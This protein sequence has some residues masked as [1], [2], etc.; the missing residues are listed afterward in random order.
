MTDAVGKDGGAEAGG[1]RE[2][3]SH[4]WDRNGFAAASAARLELG[5]VS[6]AAAHST[7]AITDNKP[8]CDR[9]NCIFSPLNRLVAHDRLRCRGVYRGRFCK[10]KRALEFLLPGA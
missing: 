8:F 5:V 10:Q 4:H 2:A 7:V 3:R 1:Q 6:K 9:Y